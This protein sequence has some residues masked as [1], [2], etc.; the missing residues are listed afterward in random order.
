MQQLTIREINMIERFVDRANLSFSHLRDDL[1]DHLCCDVEQEMAIGKNFINAYN[2]VLER[3]GVRDLKSIQ[4]NTI[5][6]INKKYNIMKKIM[7]ISGILAP[8]IMVIGAFSKI[9]HWPGANWMILFGFIVAAFL[10]L[11]SATYVMYSE[12]KSR[13]KILLHLSGLTAGIGYVLGILMKMMHWPGANIILMVG[14]TIGAIIFLPALL[15][16]LKKHSTDP[17]K[18]R[19][20]A[21]GTFAAIIYLIGFMSKILHWPAATLLLTAGGI[22]F[23][24][25]FLPMFTN[26]HIKRKF[27]INLAYIYIILAFCFVVITSMLIALRFE[28][29]KSKPNTE[30]IQNEN[31]PQKTL[32]N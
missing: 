4:E 8:V 9:M 24:M 14:M 5:K 2:D 12:Q 17:L 19:W 7:Y 1:V 18:F 16:D 13:G 28:Q 22:I 25:I 11:P 26:Y 21:I 20:Q 6:L 30:I 31:I 15:H 32:R 3:V 10:L 27:E 23:G 29:S